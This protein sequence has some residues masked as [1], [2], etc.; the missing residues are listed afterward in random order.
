MS[1]H[2]RLSWTRTSTRASRRECS[3]K[4]YI[5]PRCSSCGKPLFHG[6][7]WAVLRIWIERWHSRRLSPLA[8][9]L[10][11]QFQCQHVL[12]QSCLHHSLHLQYSLW[13]LV[14]ALFEPFALSQ[15]SVWVRHDRQGQ[16]QLN[17]QA[18]WTYSIFCHSWI[19]F[20]G[21]LH[22]QLLPFTFIE[23][24]RFVDSM[25]SQSDWRHLVTLLHLLCTS[26]LSHLEDDMSTRY[27]SLFLSCRPLRPTVW[28]LRNGSSR[29]S[30]PLHPTVCP[31][32]LSIQPTRILSPT[33]QR[34]HLSFNL[35][36]PSLRELGRT[37][38]STPDTRLLISFSQ[39]SVACAGLA[40]RSH[41]CMTQFSWLVVTHV[42]F[43]YLWSEEG[44]QSLR[45]C[46]WL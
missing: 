2:W 33:S 37:R 12:K 28:Y 9:P 18:L 40:S 14:C 7:I 11:L 27:W 15:L 24:V 20:K 5:S 42:E 30:P 21:S 32:E 26:L 41:P 43:H 13:W 16:Q 44:E 31:L 23:L 6:R 39:E 1:V 22:W 10:T 38:R 25:R 46:T 17:W 45:P 3:C 29:L 19:S 8:Y 4:T 36:G 35:V 34:T